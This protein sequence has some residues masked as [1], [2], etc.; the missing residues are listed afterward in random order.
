[1]TK[2]I[3]KYEIGRTHEDGFH[4]IATLTTSP[5]SEILFNK[6]ITHLDD[7]LNYDYLNYNDFDVII[8]LDDI[9]VPQEYHNEPIT[10]EALQTLLIFGQKEGEPHVNS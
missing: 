10:I 9:Q 1:M 5:K 8:T 6:F 2:H 7:F 3:L 4:V